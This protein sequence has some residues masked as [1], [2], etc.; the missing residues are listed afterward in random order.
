MK[1]T[2]LFICFALFL[3]LEASSQK[4]ND[5][6][7]LKRYAEA[8]KAM[9]TSSAN[10]KRIVFIG[11]SITEGWANMHP[12][13]FATNNF[14][15]RGIGGQTSPQLLSRFRND[16]VTL[17]PYAVVINVGTNDIAENSGTY[18]QNFTLGNIK[19]MVEIAKANNI[20]VILTSV[21]P[22]GYF[23]WNRAI[24]D[25]V[26]KIEGLNKEIKKYAE[27]NN[28]IYVDYHSQLKDENGALKANFSSDG[29]H[30]NDE[31]Y[32]LMEDILLNSIYPNQ[33]N[34]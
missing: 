29:V 27:T 21:L 26:D 11:N 31:C 33:S 16:V 3:T 30:P 24:T 8:N 22:A 9:P 5:L 20:Q 32:Q 6:I 34:N 18:D 4:F 1:K 2:F 17:T 19:S 10:D 23:G 12:Q 25:S 15:G 13:F 14:V 28:L 7:N